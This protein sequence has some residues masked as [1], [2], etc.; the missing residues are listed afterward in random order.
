MAGDPNTTRVSSG[1]TW[2]T[3]IWPRW[4]PIPARLP[5]IAQITAAFALM[6]AVTMPRWA[7]VPRVS[8]P[9]SLAL[10]S[11]PAATNPAPLPRGVAPVPAVIAGPAH[12]NLDVRHNFR[13]V[14]L[15][16]T[17]DGK[18]ALETKLA[19]S[20]KRFGV[21]GKRAERGFTKTLD[22]AP[23]VHLVRV[24]VRSAADKFDQS[25]VERF[26]LDSAAVASMRIAADKS[27]LSIVADRPPVAVAPP[28]PQQAPVA[29]PAMSVPQP[30]VTTQGAQLAQAAQAAHEAS[31][32]AELY[33][34]LRSILIAIA[35]FIASAAT[36]FVVESFMRSRRA[37]QFAQEA[38]AAAVP[39]RRRRVAITTE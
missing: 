11:H 33:Q 5:L 39:E 38:A 10:S 19:G 31:A 2:E 24:R 3:V 8:D 9:A 14:D 21:I 29:A 32:V 34:S 22:V 7:D 6:A 30:Q 37:L 12:L 20:G 4:L 27:G 13:S 28:A 16:V 23:G 26:A 18:P 1:S 15:S 36:G 17:V 35:G 25:R